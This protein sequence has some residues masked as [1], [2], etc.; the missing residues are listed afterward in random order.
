[1]TGRLAIIAILGCLGAF[2]WG[3]PGLARDRDPSLRQLKQAVQ[4]NPKDA[5]AYY[6]LGLKYELSG[7]YKQALAAYKQALALK[8]DYAQASYGV[9]SIQGRLG[10]YQTGILSLQQAL[11][12]QKDFPEARTRLAEI[13]NDYGVALGRQKYWTDAAD[14]LQKAIRLDPE[15][16]TAEA[17]RNNLGI[18]YFAQ[19]RLDDAM[20][21]F[22]DVLRRNPDS[23]QAAFNLGV[24]LLRSG[25]PHAAWS[26]YL[27]LRALDPEAA[28]QLSS[29]LYAPQSKRD[30]APQTDMDPDS[31][32]LMGRY[33]MLLNP[34]G[35]S[36]ARSFEV[37][38]G[39][40]R[41][42]GAPRSS[43]NPGGTPKSSWSPGQT[44][45]S[46]W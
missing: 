25:D 45:R 10:E 21:Q 14:I 36:A 13:Y 29:L 28:G 11:K 34:P 23:P 20:G 24:A 8:P 5:E 35:E 32:K 1:M 15:G 27:K 19:G 7:Q 12:Q 3:A 33:Q 26:Q 42:T 43:W 22:Q 31:L 30:Y 18:L 2:L 6:N 40:P 46:S 38:A 37:P 9:G 39:S 41:S 4:Q 16:K 17:A 44:P